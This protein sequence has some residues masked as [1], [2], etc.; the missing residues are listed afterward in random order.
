M[1]LFCQRWARSFGDLNNRNGFLQRW[2]CRLLHLNQ[3]SLL[4]F[5]LL[6]SLSTTTNG[7]EPDSLWAHTTASA[8]R[9]A[10]EQIAVQGNTYCQNQ[11]DPLRQYRVTDELCPTRH[12]VVNHLA[13][14]CRCCRYCCWRSGWYGTHINGRRY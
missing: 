3:S 4:F 7:F 13:R 14:L 2:C 9:D 5:F 6:L 1:S 11:H 12:E 8:C 10:L